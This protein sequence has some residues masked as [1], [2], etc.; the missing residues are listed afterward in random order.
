MILFNNI[1][2]TKY[3]ELEPRGEKSFYIGVSD[4]G[5]QCTYSVTTRPSAHYS[6]HEARNK[7]S[8]NKFIIIKIDPLV[9]KV[10]ISNY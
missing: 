4:K 3:V 9:I 5:L 6:Q 1:I 2:I 10:L 7:F 8:L